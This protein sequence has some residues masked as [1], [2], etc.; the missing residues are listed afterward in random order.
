MRL[1][2]APTDWHSHLLTLSLSHTNSI[3]FP[4]LSLSPLLN[5]VLLCTYIPLRCSPLLIS[6]AFPLKTK[7]PR[8]DG[9]EIDKHTVHK[10][11]MMCLLVRIYASKIYDMTLIE[12]YLTSKIENFENMFFIFPL[13]EIDL[14]CE[15]EFCLFIFF[16]GLQK[17]PAKL[18]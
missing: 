8:H 2:L 7:N 12:Y 6:V 14:N 4:F 5:L 1:D 9:K 16:L 13:I 3:Y 18:E 15:E 10:L 17:R 11:L